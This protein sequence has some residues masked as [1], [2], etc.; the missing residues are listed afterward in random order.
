MLSVSH[1][2]RSAYNTATQ[3]VSH[4]I[5]LT[6]YGSGLNSGPVT[7]DFHEGSG[8]L[9]STPRG[10][11]FSNCLDETNTAVYDG[12]VSFTY[13]QPYK[14]NIEKLG[15]PDKKYYQRLTRKPWDISTTE[16]VEL[17]FRKRYLQ[18]YF[19]SFLIFMSIVV[20][21]K[22]MQYAGLRGSDGFWVLLPKGE[23]R[24]F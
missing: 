7:S 4:G 22:E 1:I 17:M 2:R 16:W 11:K 14:V 20:M 24:R 5:G 3:T 15:M 10:V 21:N 12:N 9:K 18:L 23:T 8:M 19:Y 6:H 13:F